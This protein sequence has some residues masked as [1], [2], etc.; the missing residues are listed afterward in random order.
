MPVESGREVRFCR[1]ITSALVDCFCFLVERLGR[2]KKS[3]SHS[4]EHGQGSSSVYS[5]DGRAPRRFD[6]KCSIDYRSVLLSPQSSSARASAPRGQINKRDLADL[7]P[8]S[9]ATR[10]S[11]TEMFSDAKTVFLSDSNFFLA[12][13]INFRGARI[14]FFQ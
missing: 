2:G 9:Q 14:F 12:A 13:R 1:H 4:E 11:L 8:Q 3:R 5:Q 6:T 7:R 10:V